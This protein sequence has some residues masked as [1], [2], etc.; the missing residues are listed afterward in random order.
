MRNRGPLV[1]VGILC[2]VTFALSVSALS[3][4][5][6]A[7]VHPIQLANPFDGSTSST[8]PLR[9]FSLSSVANAS[10][11][12][13]TVSEVGLP[14]G[15]LW[16]VGTTASAMG[17]VSS[18]S[19]VSSNLTQ[20]WSNGTYTFT[21]S[22][23]L[24]NFTSTS[25][26]STFAVAGKS[27]M[28]PVHFFHA[29]SV[30]FS[31]SGITNFTAWTV[32]IRGNGSTVNAT[33]TGGALTLTVPLGPFNY[34]VGAAGYSASPAHGTGTISGPANVSVVF[35]PTPPDPGYITGDVAVGTADL[36]INGLRAIIQVGGGF[37]FTLEPGLYSF[38]V[39][40]TGY[41]TNYTEVYLTSNQTIVLDFDLIGDSTPVVPNVAVPGID[42]S[43]WVIIGVLSAAVVALGV[44]SAV[45]ARR[46]RRPPPSTP[47]TNPL[48][49]R[50]EAQ[51][52]GPSGPP[53]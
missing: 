3:G 40:A 9:T 39:T 51:T 20:W 18:N 16:Q 10:L 13:V 24:A 34:S 35:V 49:P 23:D 32:S 6:V 12:N 47:W 41:V 46:G 48:A 14:A 1:C 17:F 52:E 28:V 26:N 29:Y 4:S 25:A 50:E 33:S 31:E 19:S 45:I 7:G 53:T 43:G 44:T 36:Y 2:V 5:I 8:V 11:F 22:A 15:T 30:R 42:T 21:A 27:L 38:I 37:Y